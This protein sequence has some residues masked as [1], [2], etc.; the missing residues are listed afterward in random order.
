MGQA[1]ETGQAGRPA[2]VAVIVVSYGSAALVD[3][4]FSPLD[5]GATGIDVIVVDCFSTEAETERVREM[6]AH[7]GWTPLPLEENLGFG[8]GVNRGAELALARGADAL[9]VVNPDATL[10]AAAVH[11]LAVSVSS[12]PDAMV[13]PTITRPDG[14]LWSV[15]SDVYLDDGSMAGVR[16]R[17]AFGNRPRRFWLTG[18]CFAISRDLWSR[19]GGFDDDYFLY[20]ED[21]DFSVRV[22]EAG[23]TLRVLDDVFAVHDEGGTHDDRSTSRAK[24]ETY[25]YYNIRN[26]LLFARLRLDADT[27]LRW[28][29]TALRASW[30]ILLQGGR[31]QLVTSAA[32]W[33][34][35]RRGLRDGRRGVTGPFRG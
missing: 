24:S 1:G 35:L 12:D 14:T 13:A 3:Q 17:A 29:R 32:P 6:C 20:W 8:G 30:G 2:R 22:E 10:D 28:Q 4:N 15:G 23:G 16:R 7:R 33:R 26:R 5:S 21:V 11:R 9:V 18:A 27:R 25:Y 31:R 19:V 34:A